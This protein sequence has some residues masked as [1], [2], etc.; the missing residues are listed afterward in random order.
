MTLVGCAVAAPTAPATQAF[1]PRG[2]DRMAARIV[3][4]DWC[5]LARYARARRL[6]HLSEA[7][8]RNL[9]EARQLARRRP[10]GCAVARDVAH[11]RHERIPPDRAAWV[12]QGCPRGHLLALR[13]G[14]RTTAASLAA[15]IEPRS[16][17]PVVRSVD[18]RARRGPV[19]A[20]GDRVAERT[21]I[22]GLAL[23]AYFPSASLSQRVVAVS[24]FRRYGWRVWLLLH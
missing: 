18:A 13:A 8:R 16:L 3:Q 15:A 23:T 2:N 1:A 5:D 10:W 19:R 22:V 20:C 4:R 24:R 12:R 21:V 6:G 7:M 9:F 17:R 14:D 11:A